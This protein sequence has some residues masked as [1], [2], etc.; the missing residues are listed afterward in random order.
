MFARRTFPA[1]A[2][3]ALLAVTANGA[4]AAWPEK[5]VNYII[6]F[7]P[8]GESDVA[9]RMQQTPF[10]GI[11]GQDLIVQYMAGAGGA[12][13]WS[14]L[15]KMEADG[16]TIMGTNLPHI[17]LQPLQSKETGYQTEDLTNVYFFQYTPDALIVPA[18]SPH[19]TVDDFVKAAKDQPGA[20]ITAGSGTFS[21]N[22]LAQQ[23]FNGLAGINTTYVPMSGTAPSVTA[24]LGNQVNA[25]WGY[26]TIGVQQ[27]DKV[28]VLA[29]AMDE[30]HPAMPDVPTFK[31]LGY[32][33]VSGVYRGIAVPQATPEEVRKQVS[34]VFDQVNH[35]PQFREQMTKEGFVVVDIGYDEMP[36]F[37][38]KLRT[39]YTELAQNL[40]MVN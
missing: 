5:P 21:G 36:A 10:K 26:S 8:G 25:I 20:V 17:I 9:A 13:A 23:R 3:A 29:V 28:R 19:Q 6:A 24:L 34:D 38:D 1:L 18:N 4:W 11:T 12:A 30:R 14:Q 39:E 32:D 37:L 22:H 2:L 7:N 16:H 27:G 15:N 35:D 40:G 33:M 31:E